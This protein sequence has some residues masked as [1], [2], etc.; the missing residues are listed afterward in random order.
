MA[1][2]G[3]AGGTQVARAGDGG[4]AA[5]AQPQQNAGSMLFSIRMGIF[6]YFAMQMSNPKKPTNP[7]LLTN[8]LFIKG[9]D[10]ISP[11]L[12][13]DPT[14]SMIE[15]E[16]DELKILYGREP[17]FA[18]NYNGSLHS[19]FSLRLFGLQKRYVSKIFCYI[20]IWNENKSMEGLSA[21]S[22]VINF[23]CQLIVFLYLLD[24]E[25][26]WMILLSAGVGVGIEFW[27][28]VK[29]MIIE[30][31][32]SGK[33]SRLSFKDRES[34][35]RNK[36]KEYDDLAMKY[37]SNAFEDSEFLNCVLIRIR[38]SFANFSTEV[39]D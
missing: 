27:K 9:E 28:I 31:D 14:G 34:Y 7:D 12:Y 30:V 3:G 4:A 1:P 25:T 15:G 21:R 10:L 11:L 6:W 13:T 17:G 5:Q 19:P 37:L 16:A 36:T 29:A 24:N 18:R 33:I 2:P 8:N 35:A 38:L 22:V 23:F 20:Q 26:S 39:R 32:R